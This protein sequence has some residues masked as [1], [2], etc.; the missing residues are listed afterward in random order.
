MSRSQSKI[1]VFKTGYK[2]IDDHCKPSRLDPETGAMVNDFRQLKLK[3]YYKIM[4]LCNEQGVTLSRKLLD[5]GS[6]SVRLFVFFLVIR[7]NATFMCNHAHSCFKKRKV[8]Q[9]NHVIQQIYVTLNMV[10]LIWL[11]CLCYLSVTPPRWQAYK[12]DAEAGN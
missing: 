8:P 10:P 3:E 11:I 9:I 5:K 2:P 7:I 6:F 1:A 4:K 12:D